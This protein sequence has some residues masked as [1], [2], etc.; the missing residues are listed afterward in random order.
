MTDNFELYQKFQFGDDKAED[1]VITAK[2]I[3][4]NKNI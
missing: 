1:D 3:R 4:K 2:P